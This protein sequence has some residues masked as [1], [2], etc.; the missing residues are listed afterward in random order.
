MPAGSRQGDVYAI[1]ANGKLKWSYPLPV[2]DASPVIDGSGDLYVGAWDGKVYAF[3][4]S[5][6]ASATKVTASASVTSVKRGSQ[7]MLWG[8]VA[9]SPALVGQIVRVEVKKPGKTYWSYSS[10]RGIYSGTGGVASWQY[11]YT[12]K[13]G[14][15]KGTYLLRAVLPPSASYAT[16]T[17]AT[18]KVVVK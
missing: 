11:K 14:M 10:A 2:L 13:A 1:D 6:D 3:G 4:P 18:T 5:G 15:M 16:T 7:F 12:L 8:F 17:S 9:P